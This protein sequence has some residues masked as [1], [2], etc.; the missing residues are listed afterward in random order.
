MANN[1]RAVSIVLGVAA[2]SVLCVAAEAPRCEPIRVAVYDDAGSEGFV[3]PVLKALEGRPGVMVGRVKAAEIRDGRLVGF[4]VLIQPG[5]GGGTQGRTLGDAGRE[6]VREFVK[7]GGGYVGLCAGT[8]LAVGDY[9]WS[10]GLIDAKVVDDEHWARGE[11]EIELAATPRGREVLGL[12]E[13]KVLF[14]YENGP[15]L[16]PARNP[17]LP[18]YEPLATFA[19]EVAEN[20]APRGVMPGTTAIAAGRYGKGRVLCFSPHPERT[21]GMRDVVGRGVSWAAGR[22]R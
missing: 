4:D 5:G 18:D 6:R 3:E 11:G 12:G 15:L 21:A 9:E 14:Q 22:R 19:G 16:A 7:R 17:E 10:L 1:V 13:G 2:I 20:D 8:Y